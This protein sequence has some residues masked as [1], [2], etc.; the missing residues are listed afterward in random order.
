M[1]PGTHVRII[2]SAT[3]KDGVGIIA[4]R[5]AGLTGVVMNV[6]KWT[7]N[8]K[9]EDCAAIVFDVPVKGKPWTG[10][11]TTCVLPVW[12][13]EPCEG[14]GSEHARRMAAIDVLLRGGK[15]ERVLYAVAARMSGQEWNADM[16]DDIAR[17]LRDAGIP[18]ADLDE[19]EEAA[20]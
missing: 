10:D 13:V 2:A 1:E 9:T 11:D 15:I 19:G 4:P 18:I 12:C 14:A 5:F 8:G 16:C 7:R 17:I 3:T 6:R 20:T